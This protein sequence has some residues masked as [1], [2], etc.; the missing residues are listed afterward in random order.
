MIVRNRYH[1]ALFVDFYQLTMVQLYYRYGLHNQRVTFD[2][3]FRNYP[4]YGAHKAGYCINA[5]LETF[6]S[7]LLSLHFS[8]TDIDYLRNQYGRSLQP[9]FT[10]DFLNWLTKEDLMSSVS[11]L[12]IP[13]GRVVHKNEPLCVVEAYLAVAQM[14]ES[15]LLNICNFQTLIATRASRIKEAGERQPVIEFGMRRAHGSA[16]DE[17]SR[18]ALIGGADYSSNTGLSCRIG[19]PPKGTHAHSMVQLFIALGEGELGAFRAYAEMYPD[20]CLLL[21]DTINTL[22]SG[23]PNAIRV[24]EELRIRGHEP[25]GIRLDSGD[26][27]YLAIKSAAMLDRAGFGDTIIVLSNN[28]DELVLMQVLRQIRDE[29]PKYG[30]DPGKLIKRLTYGVGTRLVTSQGD[31]ALDG[32]YKLTSVCKATKWIPTMKI[33]ETSDKTILPGRKKLWRIYGDDTN[34][35]A[36]LIGLD[37]E[38][39]EQ[40]DSLL[41]RHS[42]R[43]DVFRVITKKNLSKIE[44]MMESVIDGGKLC[45][46]FPDLA[47]I[48][49]V[50]DADLNR[51]DVGVKRIVNPH[52]Y[53]VSISQQL[54]NLKENLSQSHTMINRGEINL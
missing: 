12:A 30:V 29:A 40:A 46:S 22:E 49:S 27:A 7:N 4:D 15:S 44:M 1:D 50:R 2:Y 11:V 26:L 5:G 8:S 34:A 23:V 28:I 52:I 47:Q 53:H 33:S 35:T 3:F 10:S 19:L 32:V 38:L 51:L 20:D 25:V 31:S 45:Y 13:E 48:R 24:F 39:V 41:L 37:D 42:L 36:D 21:V 9:V 18:A 14:I 6:C 17:A 43:S 16:A 54:W